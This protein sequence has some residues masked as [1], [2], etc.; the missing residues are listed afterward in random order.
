MWPWQG[1]LQGPRRFLAAAGIAPSDQARCFVALPCFL[2]IAMETHGQEH[3]CLT[4][5]D[6]EQSSRRAA[7]GTPSFKEVVHFSCTMRHP[8]LNAETNIRC[9]ICVCAVSRTEELLLVL[10]SPPALPA[11]WRTFGGTLFCTPLPCFP[12]FVC[13]LSRGLATALC[14]PRYCCVAASSRDDNTAPLL[15]SQHHHQHPYHSSAG[16]LLR[17][18]ER[19]WTSA[20]RRTTSSAATLR[21]RHGSRSAARR[22]WTRLRA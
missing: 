10:L 20:W 14:P 5:T 8:C 1:P 6:R 3:C 4:L 11:P 15:P 22:T 16:G 9:T 2:P 21:S 13:N 18:S 17:A 7:D 12:F 19:R